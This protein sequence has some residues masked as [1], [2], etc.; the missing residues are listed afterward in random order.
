[1]GKHWEESW[2]LGNSK[3][4]RNEVMLGKKKKKVQSLRTSRWSCRRQLEGLR[5]CVLS[6]PPSLSPGTLG[7]P[8]SFL[9]RGQRERRCRADPPCSPQAETGPRLWGA[10][11]ILQAGLTRLEPSLAPTF[12]ALSLAHSHGEGLRKERRVQ[13]KQ[14]NLTFFTWFLHDKDALLVFYLMRAPPW[15]TGA[16]D[17]RG[18]IR[19]V[20]INELQRD[21]R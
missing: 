10:A 18:P 5:L 16:R 11:Q 20:W 7:F 19:S 3:R 2:A 4:P 1:M 9:P 17:L 12:R 21:H 8:Q 6:K 15:N 13:L 14:T